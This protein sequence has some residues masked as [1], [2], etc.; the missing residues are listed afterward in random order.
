[1]LTTE[2]PQDGVVRLIIAPDR[3]AEVDELIH[4]LIADERLRIEPLSP[5]GC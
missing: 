2:H 5:N 1:V 4:R 3:E